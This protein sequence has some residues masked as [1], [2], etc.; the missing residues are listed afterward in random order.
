MHTLNPRKHLAAT[1]PLFGLLA[2][3]VLAVPQADAGVFL[4]GSDINDDILYKI[5][6]DDGTATAIGPFSRTSGSFNDVIFGMT[7]NSNTNTLFA[8]DVNADDL[9]T[10]D[11]VTA[12]VTVVGLTGLNKLE[13]LAYDSA[14]DTMYGIDQRVGPG[15][16]ADAEDFLI[17]VNMTTGAA[18]PAI[19]GTGF[20][21]I[22]DLAIDPA[23]GTLYGADRESNQLLTINKTTGAATVVGALGFGNVGGL[24]FHPFTG[25]LFGVDAGADVLLSIDKTT[26]T[27][28]QIGDDFALRGDDSD[29]RIEGIAFVPEPGSMTLLGLGSLL[30]LGRT[31]RASR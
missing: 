6:T 30:I 13:A 16:D 18:E 27:A 4:V 15:G 5:D 28:T 31:R 24:D 25:E 26:G 23:D 22:Q 7:F 21:L 9:V 17:T 1:L 19:G 29:R 8:T 2:A 12:A 3:L 11:P 10:I 20:D 14:T